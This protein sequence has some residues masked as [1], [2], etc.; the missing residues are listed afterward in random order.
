MRLRVAL[1]LLASASVCEAAPRSLD[2]Y[3]IDV[4]GGQSTLLVTPDKQSYLI[5]TGYAGSGGP[6]ASPAPG[7]PTKA[8]DANRIVAAAHD[9][10]IKQ[11]DYLMIT[12]F[13]PDHDGGVVELSKLLP[14]R[15]FVDHDTLLPE[16]QKDAG[17]RSAY[18]RYLEVRKG[19]PHIIA[20]PGDRLPLTGI[21]TVVVSSGG[22]VLTQPLPGAGAT[23][24]LCGSQAVPPNDAL[25][26]PRSTGVVVTLG[27]FRFLDVG[28][29]TG[30]PL[31]SLAC[32]KSL[33]GPVSVYLAAHHGGSDTADPAIFA[34]FQPRVVVMN[35]G[36]KKGGA[37]NTYA[38][39]HQVAGLADVWQIHESSAAQEQ[40]FSA[41]HIANLD[42]ST[43]YWIKLS[44]QADG[45]F[46]VVNGRTGQ[47]KSYP[48]GGG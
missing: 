20:E 2:I 12:H 25:E 3:F 34:A 40:N 29:L 41:A 11:I 28:D 47:A 42:E 14:I 38:T 32:P 16:A 24:S 26:N 13:H 23:N 8:R 35:N 37:K 39:L 10:G 33:I 46:K 22:S 15:H 44:A 21:E 17:T 18:E 1:T 48:A 4:E 7:D 43:G 45:S 30:T 19:Q 36:L 6:E 9:A 27:K 5:D 31:F